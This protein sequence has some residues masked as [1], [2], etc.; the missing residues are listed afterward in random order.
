MKNESIWLK[1]IKQ[2]VSKSLDRNIDVDVLIIG[3]GITGLSVAYHLKE[4]NLKVCLVEK[5]TIGSGITAKTTGKLTFLQELIYQDIEK[6]YDLD[7][8]KLY[9]NS[10]VDAIKLVSDIVNE[11]NI[12]C[13]FE[14]VDSFVFTLKDKEEPKIKKEKE[15]LELFEVNVKEC[16]MLPDKTDIKFGISVANT[17]VFHPLKYLFKLKEIVNKKIDIYENTKI[18]DIKKEE[19]FICRTQSFI[20]KAKKV[21]L[22]L[23]YPY[24]LVPYFFP[25]KTTLEK[26]YISAFEVEKDDFFSAITCS[27]PT[28]SMRYLNNDKSV[29]KIYLTNSHNIAIKNNE[30]NNF[31]ELLIKS[32]KKPQFMW[33]NIDIKTFDKLPL[34]GEIDKG[35]YLATGY[36]TWGM[37]NGSIAGKII[38][39]QILDIQNKY[40]LLFDPKRSLKKKIIN[41]PLVIG[42]N[43]KSFVGS[44]INKNKSW[45]G[46][47]VYFVGNKGIFIDSDGKKHVIYNKCPH[48]KCGLIFN[49][50]EKTWDCPCHGSRFD[51]DGNCIEGPSN[52]NI[53]YRND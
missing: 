41:F 15:I 29:Y 14:K 20:I 16:N 34:V 46:D 4:S 30:L 35:L 45:Y 44:K 22:A 2:N 49:E 11:E 31:E 24:F 32:P 7:K 33:S 28:I 51:I 12:N 8:A 19:D 5:N 6:M 13:D 26:S 47:N 39:D 23:H 40:S 52:Y 38:A 37:T 27:N 50:I 21:V 3:G 18:I 53:K 10:Q 25:L 43:V 42:S 1:N 36:N 9:Y 48:L 17:A